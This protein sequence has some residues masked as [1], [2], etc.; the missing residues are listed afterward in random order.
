MSSDLTGHDY[1]LRAG[2]LLISVILTAGA[3]PLPSLACP[4]QDTLRTI[5][6]DDF[7]KNRPKGR[8]PPKPAGKSAKVSSG[9]PSSGRS[10]RLASSPLTPPGPKGDGSAATQLGL[11]LW[12]LRRARVG[13]LHPEPSGWIAER[14]EA[15]AEFHEGDYLR[16]SIESPRAGYLYV[17]DRDW[18]KNGY[19]GETSLIFPILNDDNRLSAGRLIDIPA[20]DQSPFKA[21]PKPNQAGEVL[22]IIVSSKPLRLPIS[23]KPL[24]I[25]NAQLREWEELW[26]GWTEHFELQGGAG[27]IRSRQEQ[28]AAAKKG[29]RQL[30]RD[31]PAPQ[32]MYRLTQK[33][34]D[35]FLINLRISYTR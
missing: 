7:T 3:L 1:R 17:I 33:N 6:S 30:T 27:R 34:S 12:K 19:V 24:P 14:V 5:V 9:D 25:S 35:A 31:D 11:T 2:R 32:T 16:L 10:Y 18:F 26:G 13:D 28:Q 21:S 4:P 23:N 8:R 22:T 15:D 20:E 29:L